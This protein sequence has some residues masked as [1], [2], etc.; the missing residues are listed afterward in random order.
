MQKATN[1]DA[2]PAHYEQFMW[3]SYPEAGSK[4][5]SLTQI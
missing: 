4:A 5:I 2:E 1:L 3:L